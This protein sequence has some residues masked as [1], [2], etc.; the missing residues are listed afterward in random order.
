MK[1]SADYYRQFK[2]IIIVG[3]SS[4]IGLCLAKELLCET[5]TISLISRD[6]EKLNFAKNKLIETNKSGSVFCF[7]ADVANQT[8]IETALK[9]AIDIMNGIDLLIVTAGM[10]RPGLSL[11]HDIQH[12]QSIIAVNYLGSV[13]CVQY[14]LPFLKQN[15]CAKI[16]LTS[17]VAGL[18]PIFGYSAYAPT[19]S[20]VRIY[21][22]I[23]QQE[24]DGTTVSLSILYPPDT[25]TSQLHYE[26]KLKPRITKLITE[27]G[28]LWQPEEVAI[29]TLRRLKKDTIIPGF[30]SKLMLY[31][32]GILGPI[33]KVY[34]RILHRKIENQK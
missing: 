23:L 18:I 15:Q 20:A 33:I 26:E 34:S 10:V 16:L 9:Q 8:E 31:F 6:K 29:Y 2:K 1:Q 24:L 5:N 25:D 27:K 14:C 28:G 21:G 3:G 17:S 7:P 30:V 19:K 4:G 12:Y 13:Y 11:H 22:Q 32:S